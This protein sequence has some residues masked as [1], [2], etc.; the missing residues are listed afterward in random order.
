MQMSLSSVERLDMW[1]T[2]MRSYLRDLLIDVPQEIYVKV[3]LKSAELI[4]NLC[5][6]HTR[7]QEKE[8]VPFIWHEEVD[9][10]RREL[11]MCAMG[12][13]VSA[14]DNAIG[15]KLLIT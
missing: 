11:I 9:G 12:W 3:D 15:G 8:E 5:L 2:A 1:R 4:C 13:F 14:I 6:M 10:L 7:I